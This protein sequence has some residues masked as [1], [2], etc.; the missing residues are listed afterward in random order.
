[1][2][3]ALTW[4]EVKGK[5]QP[6]T[7]SDGR[8]LYLQVTSAEAKSWILRYQ[9]DGR[10][11][12]MGLGSIA[13]I[14]LARARDLAQEARSLL[15]RGQDPIEHRE[16]LR[17]SQRVAEAQAVTFKQAAEIYILNHEGTWRNAKHRWQWRH[18]L[19]SH[20]YP[21]FGDL[22]VGAIDTALVLKVLE[23]IWHKQPETAGRLRGRI[24]TVLAAAT[25]RGQRSGPNPAQ[26]RNHLDQLLPRRSK[27]RKVRHQPALPYAE[28]PELMA[29]LARLDSVSARAL[30]F[31]ILTAARTGEVIGMHWREIDTEAGL[32]SVP[33]ERMKAARTHRVPLSD[34]AMAIIV[35]MG[36]TRI[37]SF[38]FPGWRDK[39]PLSNMA[40]LEC[41]RGLRS[42]FTV[43]GFRSSF[44]DWAAEQTSF[45][46]IVAE[47]AL[48]H[49]VADKTEAAYRR[50]DLMEKRRQLM[51]AWADFCCGMLSPQFAQSGQ[52]GATVGTANPLR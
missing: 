7:Y 1:M 11:R 23:P 17:A 52:K 47:A 39:Q 19:E 33:G 10:R 5:K 32:W 48:A 20:A 31:T 50:G 15:A 37:S 34:A 21:V 36:R 14:S 42:G 3:M 30:A 27:V 40:M 24:E 13:D 29:E 51:Q 9:L 22:P 16:A 44:R 4:A 8:G 26:W 6:G 38:V 18:T 49:V 46:N 28:I 2:L 35:E 12:M 43:H 41:L 45:P 25:A